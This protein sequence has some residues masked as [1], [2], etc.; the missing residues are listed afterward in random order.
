MVDARAY[1]L[2]VIDK[3][4]EILERGCGHRTAIIRP[5]AKADAEGGEIVLASGYDGEPSGRPARDVRRHC[6]RAAPP[7]QGPASFFVADIR[8]MIVG[9]FEQRRE[10]AER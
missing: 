6:P 5:V 3:Y 2:G 1:V 7:R 10:A 4:R 9:T 8:W